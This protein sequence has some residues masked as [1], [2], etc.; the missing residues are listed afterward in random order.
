MKKKGITKLEGKEGDEHDDF[1]KRTGAEE[2]RKD[3]DEYGND[4]ASN[5]IWKR[6]KARNQKSVEVCGSEFADWDWAD[7]T[8]V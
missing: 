5:K 7:K 8:Q 2:E 3:K 1:E 6:R 4:K